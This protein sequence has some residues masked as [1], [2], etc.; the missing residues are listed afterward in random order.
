MRTF[1]LKIFLTLFFTGRKYSSPGI[2]IVGSPR[3]CIAVKFGHHRLKGY[4]SFYLIRIYLSIIFHLQ[5]GQEVTPFLSLSSISSFMD[6]GRPSLVVTVISSSYNYLL[7]T[8]QSSYSYSSPFFED[9]YRSLARSCISQ[10]C[11]GYCRMPTPRGF[12]TTLW[13]YFTWS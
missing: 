7:Q 3:A 4:K 10:T 9:G 13:I 8:V 5:G 6:Y 2:L 12:I 11:P 1:K